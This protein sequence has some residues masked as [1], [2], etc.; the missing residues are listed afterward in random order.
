MRELTIFS[1]VVA[2][3]NEHPAAGEPS[4]NPDQGR[5]KV[6]WSTTYRS[7]IHCGQSLKS[8]VTF[9]NFPKLFCTN[10]SFSLV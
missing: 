5:R 6:L 2:A 4:P 10:F 1:Q 8:C 7:V 9:Q 3:T